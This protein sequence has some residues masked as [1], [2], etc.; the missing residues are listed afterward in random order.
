MEDPEKLFEPREFVGSNGQ[1]LKYRL[2]KPAP[3]D[4]ERKYP[5]VIFLHGA[6]ERGSDNVAQ[7]KHGMAEFCKAKWR[8]KYPCYVLAP[9]CPEGQKWSDVDWSAPHSELPAKTSQS[10]QLVFDLV[11]TMIKDA[12]VNDNRVI[13]TGLSMGGYGTWDALARRPSLFAAAVPICGGGDPKTADRFAQVPIWCFHG[14]QDQ[15]VPVSRSREMVEALKAAGGHPKYTEY[16][17][18]GHNS[19]AQTYADPAVLEWL[20]TQLRRDTTPTTAEQKEPDRSSN[21]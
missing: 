20:F 13:I 1:T 9:Q 15:A 14:D 12:A 4:A 18:V 11:D 7:L 5:L 10:M 19:W 2:L 8:D 3:Y 21:Q 6:G 17:G 16:P